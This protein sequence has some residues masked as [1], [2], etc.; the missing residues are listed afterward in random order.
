MKNS[1]NTL[2]ISGISPGPSLTELIIKENNFFKKTGFSG[3]VFYPGML[4]NEQNNWWG[5]KGKRIRPHEG[6]DLRYYYD[7]TGNVCSVGANMRVPSPYDGTIVS[8]M[9]D[10]LGH[11][12]VI[13]HSP[14][15]TG[16]AICLTIFGHTEPLPELVVGR[17]V[18]TGE[19]LA[20]LAATKI[21]K[22]P[23]PAHLHVT[24]IHNRNIRQASY[25]DLDWSAI[26][27]PGLFLLVD[28]IDIL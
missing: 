16:N 4:F 23:V 7:K 10:F 21:K 26:A 12:I 17:H 25:V 14:G 28:P 22:K 24:I 1:D 13:E 2:L 3:W 18:R 11:S 6:L 8:I 19:A 9:P 27:D 20:V 15:I 5:R